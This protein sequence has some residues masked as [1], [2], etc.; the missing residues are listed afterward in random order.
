[1][2]TPRWAKG[3]GVAVAVGTAVVRLGLRVGGVT[4]VGVG[5]GTAA[6]VVGVAVPVRWV[7]VRMEMISGVG[8][9]V[10]DSVCVAVG[11]EVSLS[12]GA[13]VR[14]G[15]SVGVGVGAG[16]PL[17]AASAPARSNMNKARCVI[18]VFFLFL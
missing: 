8:S 2:S 9:A 7:P 16:T 4:R 17:Q 1:M 13:P 6:G 3:E 11:A 15:V 10:G 14:A 5:V 18:G 12:S